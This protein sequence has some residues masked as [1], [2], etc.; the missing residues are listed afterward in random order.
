MSC[1]RIQSEAIPQEKTTP[2]TSHAMKRRP[3]QILEGYDLSEETTRQV[4]LVAACRGFRP[5]TG[6]LLLRLPNDD[7]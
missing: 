3:G 2:E 5:T 1:C 6:H 7:E 4:N